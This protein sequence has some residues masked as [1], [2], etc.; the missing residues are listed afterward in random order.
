MPDE[1]NLISSL[2]AALGDIKGPVWTTPVV[3][4]GYLYLR[5]KQKLI[6]YNLIG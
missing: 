2:P 4:N 5:F 6:C 3:S 1:F